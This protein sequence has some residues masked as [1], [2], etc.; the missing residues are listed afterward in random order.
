VFDGPLATTELR[1]KSVTDYWVLGALPKR[2]SFRTYK[3]LHQG[4]FA[5]HLG[6]DQGRVSRALRNLHEK[7]IIERR[8]KGAFVEWRLS[9]SWGWIGSAEAY[10]RSVK[11]DR[12]QLRAS[13]KVVTS[14]DPSPAA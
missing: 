8:G 4:E 13:L 6:L 10:E 14:N 11:H 2:L 1:L 7:G 5:K 9:K 12:D 3:R